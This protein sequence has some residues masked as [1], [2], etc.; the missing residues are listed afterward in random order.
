MPSLAPIVARFVLVVLLSVAAFAVAHRASA[1]PIPC[2]Q[3]LHCV[4][5]A[6][7]FP[8][9]KT[10]HPSTG[11]GR[12]EYGL[13]LRLP[14]AEAGWRPVSAEVS[15]LDGLS[16]AAGRT[17]VSL[18]SDGRLVPGTAAGRASFGEGE[19][20]WLSGPLQVRYGWQGAPGPAGGLLTGRVAGGI[21]V[22]YARIDGVAGVPASAVPEPRALLA[23]GVGALLV[24][25]GVRPAR[26]V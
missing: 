2:P 18:A 19:L 20:A 16:T 1:T 5:V 26:R 8:V 3:N 17:R 11:A 24:A 15:L 10:I 25:R 9:S 4:S 22:R 7:D 13:A 23:F 21:E 14:D 12:V 6:F